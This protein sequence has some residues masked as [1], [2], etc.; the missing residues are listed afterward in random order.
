MEQVPVSTT[1]TTEIWIE[2]QEFDT[3]IRLIATNDR[4]VTG[5]DTDTE[6]W[7]T[8]TDVA[9]GG[10]SS[11]TLHSSS[12]TYSSNDLNTFIGGFDA[13]F[14]V[15]QD[16]GTGGWTEGTYTPTASQKRLYKAVDPDNS[17]YWIAILIE[18]SSNA[19]VGITWY[20]QSNTGT[21]F[22]SSP[23]SLAFTLVTY[24]GNPS[25]NPAHIA[26]GTWYYVHSS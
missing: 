26:A 8:S 4:T 11:L 18:Q 5:F 19:L 1:K 25:T 15:E 3:F 22:A 10:V 16:I 6:Y 14:R 7:Y 17:S 12:S 13:A 21:I 24:E 9:I 23:G 2:D 20:K